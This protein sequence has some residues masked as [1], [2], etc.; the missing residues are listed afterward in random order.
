[1]KT[2]REVEAMVV[3]ARR[4][5]EGVTLAFW[6]PAALAARARAIAAREGVTLSTALVQ[7]VEFACDADDAEQL[8]KR[9][10]R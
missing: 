1:M 8:A 6:A 4:K 3:K 7:L 5:P 2:V 9:Q 10:S